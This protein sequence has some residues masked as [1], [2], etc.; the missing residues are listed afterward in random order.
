MGTLSYSKNGEPVWKVE[1]L[2]YL[3][4]YHLGWMRNL[5]QELFLGK[6]IVYFLDSFPVR[7]LQAAQQDHHRNPQ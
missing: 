4:F 1:R 7:S 5:R 6:K 2:P 3:H